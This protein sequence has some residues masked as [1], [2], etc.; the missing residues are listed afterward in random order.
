MILSTFYYSIILY[1][2]YM[3]NNNPNKE[4]K[5]NKDITEIIKSV[6]FAIF[7]ITATWWGLLITP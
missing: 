2:N 6:A 7:L 1:R 5:M 4:Q 3:I